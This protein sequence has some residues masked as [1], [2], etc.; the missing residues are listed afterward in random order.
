MI[1]DDLTDSPGNV[2]GKRI[3]SEENSAPE[4][5]IHADNPSRI[6]VS[7]RD[8]L[9]EKVLIIDVRS[10]A[11]PVRYAPPYA[12]IGSGYRNEDE[13]RCVRPDRADKGR[14]LSRRLCFKGVRFI[15]AVRLI[16]TELQNVSCLN[17]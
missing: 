13:H 17:N 6:P 16:H 11:V 12:W 1:R 14:R 10:H 4:A 15:A 5:A 3:L 2:A 8:T 9:V 7:L